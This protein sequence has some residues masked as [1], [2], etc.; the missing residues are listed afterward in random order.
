MAGGNRSLLAPWIGGAS[1]APTTQGGLKSLL[2]FWAG[3]ANS[4]EPSAIQGGFKSI[5]GYWAGGIYGQSAAEPPDEGI[6]TPTQRHVYQGRSLKREKK[7]KRNN[8]LIV[9]LD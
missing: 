6:G 1:S 4:V 5:F 8:A 7:R 9:I 2:A 3:G